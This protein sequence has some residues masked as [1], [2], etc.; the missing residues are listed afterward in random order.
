VLV[1]SW[2]VGSAGAAGAQTATVPAP[3]ITTATGGTGS[4]TLQSTTTFDLADVG[5]SGAEYI[6]SGT[7]SAYT[8]ATPLTQDGKWTVTPA[9]TAPYTTRA[10][11]YRPT[12]AKDFNGTA[13]VEWLNVSGG[14]DAN[15]DWVQMHTQMI[16]DG[17]A[18]IGVSAQANGLNATKGS[19]PE[20]YAALSHPGDSYS[21]DMYSQIGEAVRSDRTLLGG[22]KPKRVLAVGESQSAGRLVT[23]LNAIA[24]STDVFDGYLVHSR[25][26]GG[27]ALSQDPLPAIP[28]V[29]PTL[30]RD[31][32]DVPVFVYQAETDVFNSNLG[33]RQPDTKRF[34]MWEAAGTAHYD[35]YGL[36]MGFYDTGDGQGE[37]DALASMQ[38]PTNE[39][40]PGV[41]TCALAINTGPMHWHLDA[42]L[43][44]LNQWV[45]EGTPPPKAPLLETTGSSPVAYALDETGNAQGGVRS[46]HVDAPIAR[47]G[48][49]SNTGQPP[50]GQFCRLFGTTVPLTADELAARYESQRDFVKQWNKATDAALKAGYLVPEDAKLLKRA[51]AQSSVMG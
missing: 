23:Y 7:A 32:L 44:H 11:V 27:G 3:T 41:I 47:L 49:V 5:Y 2:L 29:N 35:T 48:G 46:P 9:S 25:G 26:G 21:Y 13:I 8:S 19:D 6:L 15:P 40:I 18:W 1:V 39:P 30:I 51:A 4:P 50:L 45:V 31:D 12:R 37:V 43:H 24:P 28:V 42:V 16:R 33:A 10:V 38:E 22:L 20:R 14:V 36:V 17:Y 34:R